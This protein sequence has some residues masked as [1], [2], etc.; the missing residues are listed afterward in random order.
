MKN[1]YANEIAFSVNHIKK[2]I[3]PWGWERWI[4]SGKPN[5]AYVFK[6]LYVK[7]GFR[8]SLQFHEKK[9]E[10]SIVLKGRGILYYSARAIDISRYKS[11]KYTNDEL[12]KIIKNLKRKSIVPGI[13]FHMDIGFLHRVEAIDDLLIMESSTVEVDDIFRLQDD[14]G[15][16]DE[17]KNRK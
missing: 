14:F 5:F 11:G 15:R 3:K 13:V 7:A 9:Q 1:K 12:K 17:F 16:K 2:V 10:S 8:L 6:E 4:A